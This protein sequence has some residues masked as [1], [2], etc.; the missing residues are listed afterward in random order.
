MAES[1]PQGVDSGRN[2]LEAFQWKACRLQLR[3]S[4]GFTPS[5]L[6]Y[7]TIKNIHFQIMTKSKSFFQF[8]LKLCKL[9]AEEYRSIEF[10]NNNLITD[11]YR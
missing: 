10:K 1:A 5:S 4:D 7:K 11:G 8:H 3:G 2:R 6:L 9:S